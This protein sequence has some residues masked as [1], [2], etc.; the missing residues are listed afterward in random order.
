MRC[1]EKHIGLHVKLLN[2]SNVNKNSHGSTLFIKFSNIKFQ[3]SSSHY[4]VVPCIV[5]EQTGEWTDSEIPRRSAR[6]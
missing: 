5:Y 1:T 3:N 2:M 4:Q 6:L